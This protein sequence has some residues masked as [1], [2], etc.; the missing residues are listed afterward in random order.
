MSRIVL[1]IAVNIGAVALAAHYLTGFSVSPYPIPYAGQ[2]LSQTLPP[3]WQTLLIGG[4]ALGIVNIIL[5]PLL[6]VLAALLPIITF[7][8]LSVALNV[9]LLFFADQFFIELSIASLRPLLTAGLAIGILNA[10]L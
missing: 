4:A 1:K 7:P 3:I 6:K 8:I 5:S 10:V 9:A 2:L